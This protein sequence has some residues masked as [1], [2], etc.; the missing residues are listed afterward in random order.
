[1]ITAN[2]SL[3]DHHWVFMVGIDFYDRNSKNGITNTGNIGIY[4][5]DS[6]VT[7]DD[8]ISTYKLNPENLFDRFYISLARLFKLLLITKQNEMEN[9]KL[10]IIEQGK[11]NLKLKIKE[12]IYRAMISMG[13]IIYGVKTTRQNDTVTCGLHI[14]RIFDE[15]MRI[16]HECSSTLNKKWFETKLKQSKQLRL[17]VEECPKL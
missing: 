11:D 3:L 15:I 4:L 14:I 6:L 2:I 7:L 12:D 9:N 10:F 8:N 1:M 5:F 13:D 17:C 16:N